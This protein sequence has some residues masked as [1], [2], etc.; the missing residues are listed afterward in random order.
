VVGES[1]FFRIA[2]LEPP[3]IQLALDR[4]R[5]EF[6]KGIQTV[7]LPRAT[8]RYDD[9]FRDLAKIIRGEKTLAWDSA[10]DLVVQETLLRASGMP[11][12]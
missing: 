3:K 9:E 2:P 12:D 7:E 10:H 6:K 4:P 5:G 11:L 1:G 8:G